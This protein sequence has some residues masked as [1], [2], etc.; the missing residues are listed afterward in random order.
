MLGAKIAEGREA[1]VY[2]WDA[3]D[4]AVVKLYRPGFGGHA[5]EAAALAR[6]E[7]TGLA[8]RLVDTVHLDGREGLVLQRLEGLDMLTL[9]GQQPWQLP[10]LARTLAHAALRI[11][12]VPAPPELPDLLQVLADRIVAAGLDP[13]PRDFALRLLDTLPAGDRLCHGDFHPG[14]AV[15]T[16]DSVSIIDWVAASRGTPAADFARTMLLLRQADPLPGTPLALRMLMSA[17]RS[18]F[19]NVFARSYRK[20]APEPLSRLGDWALVQA[21]ARLAEGIAAERPRLVAI[22]EAAC[23]RPAQ[24]PR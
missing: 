18:A 16:A 11:H 17:G 24:V 1:E 8:P 2:A 9:L 14:N 7:D 23:R 20:D 10:G 19:A 3:G 12:R 4:P 5:A 13:G 15:V 6:L 22:V 21:A